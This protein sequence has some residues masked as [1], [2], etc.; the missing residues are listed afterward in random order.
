MN[1]QAAA[2]VV[3]T[4]AKQVFYTINKDVSILK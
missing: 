1:P 4:Q 3:Y 2:Q